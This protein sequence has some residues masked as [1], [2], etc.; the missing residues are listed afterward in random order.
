MG[1]H[2]SPE[3]VES[4]RSLCVRII[5]RV[6]YVVASPS[7]AWRGCGPTTERIVGTG[8]QCSA[9]EPGPGFRTWVVRTAHTD[10]EI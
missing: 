7:L 8:N 6:K 4:S 1:A 9:S 2:L 3:S 10:R 5:H